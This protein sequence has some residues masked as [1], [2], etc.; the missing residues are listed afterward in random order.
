MSGGA[1]KP[2]S[3]DVAARA[4]V[5]RT[6]VSYVLNGRLDL[7][8]P[9][10]TR[11]RVFQ[12]AQELG[13]RHNQL[14]RS[15][16]SGKTLTLG[17]VL[18][19]LDEPYL[20]EIVHGVEAVCA[21]QGYRVLL[22]NSQRDAATEARQVGLL[23]ER[24]VDGLICLPSEH[25]LPHMAAWLDAAGRGGTAC[26]IADDRTFSPRF[27]CVVSD[28][29]AGARQAVDFLA[30]SGHRRIGHLAGSQ[31]VSSGRDRLSG[32]MA[33]LSAAGLPRDPALIV[34][35]TFDAVA[36]APA[37]AAL[38]RQSP[39][40]TAMFAANDVL[41]AEALEALRAQGRRVPGDIVVIGYGNMSWGRYLRLATVD[42]DAQAMGRA[43]A[44]RLFA[45][46]EEPSLPPGETLLP[47][48][49]IVRDSAGP[50]CSW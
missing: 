35:H 2:N 10:E 26:V 33:A 44:R 7:P 42:Q 43:A 36:V 49:L 5:S 37:V 11:A 28:D 4:G 3:F 16:R 24:R 38:L 18:P 27:D 19:G 1:K 9:Q 8:I 30:A 12:A 13:Y 46:L 14:A 32:Y 41:A 6:T 22:A 23:L 39:P 34:G 31:A 15:L 21:A 40:P 48:R 17:V 29:C 25:T 20:A 50:E 45:R 47:T